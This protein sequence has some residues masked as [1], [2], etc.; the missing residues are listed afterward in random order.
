MMKPIKV[1]ILLTTPKEVYEYACDVL[2]APF[3]AGEAVI[4]E[5]TYY[6]YWYARYLLKHPDP[7]SWAK[8]FKAKAKD[9]E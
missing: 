8:E 9:G 7:A 1:E 5:N 3:P 6:S 4:T 2:K